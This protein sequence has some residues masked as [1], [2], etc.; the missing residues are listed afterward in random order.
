MF[1]KILL[2]FILWRTYLLA[3]AIVG[4]YAI[5]LHTH[6][7][8]RDLA[9]GLTYFQWSWANF[10]GVN[11]LNISRYGYDYPN[12]AYFPL[13]PALI[14]LF[15]DIENMQ[16]LINL[17]RLQIGLIVSNLSLL[18]SIFLIYK[19]ALLDYDKK[20]AMRSII[21]LLGMPTAFFYGSVYA[22][23][24][25]LLLSTISFYLARQKNWLWAGIFGFLAATSRLVGIVLL[26]AL[27]VEWYLQKNPKANIFTRKFLFSLRKNYRQIVADFFTD[28]AYF[29]FLIPLGIVAYALYL[30]VEYKDFLLFQK[31][32][33][34]WGQSQTVLPLQVVVRYLKIFFVGPMSFTYFVAVVEFT[35]TFLYLALSVY[36]VKKV[37]LSY[38]IFMILL[39]LI[40]TFTGTFQ[41]MPRYILHLFPAFIGLA[42]LTR[43]YNVAF[44]I[45][46]V[47]FLLLQMLFAAL[48]SR[49][50]FVA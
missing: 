49:G 37:R 44:W 43:T 11:Y 45:M 3:A 19:T 39:L 29:L 48:F 47:C 13:Y 41:S 9:D 32:M 25:F 36:V 22:D 27:L 30:Q 21:I 24:L 46:I 8:A 35:T 31:S 7:I 18:L 17:R 1:K 6:S 34:E 33:K 10:D 2:L 16:N 42:L 38:G 20:T 28:K 26:P 50:Y 4:A 5:P 23:S 15:N 14:T 12:F 40:P